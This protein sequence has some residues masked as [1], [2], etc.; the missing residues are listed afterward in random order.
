MKTGMRKGSGRRNVSETRRVLFLFPFLFLG[1]VGLPGVARAQSAARWADSAR[2]AIENAS[3]AGNLDGLIAA[4]ALTE[5]A[6][7]R[8]PGDAWLLHYRG[9][10][11]YREATL[12]M[13]RYK[14]KDV[15]SYLE[16]AE[17]ILKESATK[18]PIAETYA[19]L[20]SVIGQQIGSNPLR[21][22]TLGPRSNAAMDDALARGPNNPRVWLL[23][24]IGARFTPKLFG[25]GDERA[26]EYLRR[27]IQLF[28]NDRVSPP[29]PSWGRD[30]AWAWLGQILEEKGQ[31]DGA[32]RAYEEALRA[33]PRNGWV[34]EELLAN[35][36]KRVR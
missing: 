15:D 17:S 31:W 9:Y 24:G 10:A 27:A 13:G 14:E 25:G 19:L 36:S 28:E 3:L 29:A 4:R 21:G 7:T 33:E 18:Q 2:V 35:L 34:R 22:M 30:D 32:R 20:S 23:R 11:L 5:R 26:E 16:Q 1:V 12:R 6:L 8:F